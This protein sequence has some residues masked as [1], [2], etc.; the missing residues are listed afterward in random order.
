MSYPVMPQR[1]IYD[2]V[3]FL[4]SENIEKLLDEIKHVDGIKELNFMPLTPYGFED[5]KSILQEKKSEKN[6]IL[7]SYVMIE[8]EKEKAEKL[9]KL[10]CSTDNVISC[11]PVK[12]KFDMV[13][14]ME[15]CSFDDID[16]VIK[17]H[18]RYMD[19]VLRIKECP[20][21]VLN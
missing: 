7:S 11:Y 19:G 12:G 16:K 8:A 17:E 21:I 9:Y 5:G 18:I 4:K 3:L 6:D 13:L 1:G 14:L 2:I 20:V 10:L 15:S